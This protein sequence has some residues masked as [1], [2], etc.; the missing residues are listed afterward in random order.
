MNQSTAQS[1]YELER[2][3]QVIYSTALSRFLCRVS[4]HWWAKEYSLLHATQF[5]EQWL[6][7]LEETYGEMLAKDPL[8]RLFGSLAN[9]WLQDWRHECDE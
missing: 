2:I 7:C 3:Y 6:N 8:Q 5:I 9:G 4:I 1:W